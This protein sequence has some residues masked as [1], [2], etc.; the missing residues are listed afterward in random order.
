M[1]GL[2]SAGKYKEVSTDVL[3]LDALRELGRREEAREPRRFEENLTAATPQDLLTICY[4]SGT[5]GI[6]KGAML[7][8]DAMMSVM[9][10]LVSCLA[11]F[12]EAR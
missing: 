12:R 1:A 4:T 11:P 10:D 8:H 3:S 6:P 2:G 7:T 9:E 5:T